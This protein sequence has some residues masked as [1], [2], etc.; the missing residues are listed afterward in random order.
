MNQRLLISAVFAIT[1]FSLG[2]C[3]KSADVLVPFTPVNY[4]STSPLLTRFTP[5]YALPNS[6]ISLIGTNF[7]TD[8][9]KI[10]V[11]FGGVAATVYSATATEIVVGVP[12]TAQTGAIVLVCNGVT[13]KSSSN[14]VVVGGTQTTYATGYFEHVALDLSN[15]I[16]GENNNSITRSSPSGVIV[17]L[18]NGATAVVTGTPTVGLKSI[19]GVAVDG[20][21]NLYI[22]EQGN[23]RID[24]LA[25]GAGGV[26]AILAGN[27]TAAYTDGTGTAAS[28][29]T[30]P[31]GLAI[32]LSGNLYTT[33]GL[34]VRKITPAG[35]VTTVAGTGV[36]GNVDGPAAS[37][38]FGG[39]EGIAV[40]AAGNIYVDDTGNKTIRKITA[41]GVVSTLAGTAGTAGFADGLGTAAT[42][43]APQ[44]MAVDAAGNVFVSDNQYTATS[45]VYAIRMINK[46]G[47]VTTFMKNT[48]AST[49][50]A[51]T[52]ITN[53]AL[54]VA[55]T[56][57]PDGIAFDSAGNMYVANTGAGVVSIISFK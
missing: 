31:R 54:S 19:W 28:F 10:S 45:V 16:Y 17:A 24:K 49:A 56:N 2:S 52:T 55:T 38:Q 21:G 3:K 13:L 6:A 29:L 11:T 4:S 50:A 36:A 9:S 5:G 33:D 23:K 1:V 20:S 8:V 18:V 12:A 26:L 7:P 43:N 27:G 41:A 48:Y 25:A 40:D 47:L 34:R 32:D 42:F 22:A 53:G 35:V 57:F 37:A 15:F 14:F 51:P 30:G 44:G 39:L 46:A